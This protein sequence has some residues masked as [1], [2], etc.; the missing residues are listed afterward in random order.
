MPDGVY[1]CATHQTP[2]HQANHLAIVNL[3][4]AIGPHSHLSET[5]ISQSA[6][7]DFTFWNSLGFL[8]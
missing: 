3:R 4:S 8:G 5:L 7:R 6:T 1:I 2:L